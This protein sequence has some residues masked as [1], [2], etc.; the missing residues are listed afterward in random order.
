MWNQESRFGWTVS[1][2]EQ[3]QTILKVKRRGAAYIG[4][5]TAEMNQEG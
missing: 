2:V 3:E 4:E 5:D 1:S